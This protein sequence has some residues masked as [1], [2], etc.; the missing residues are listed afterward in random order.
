MLVAPIHGRL[1]LSGGP[2]DDGFAE[3]L[4]DQVLTGVAARR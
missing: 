2:I 4:V 1:L 3:R